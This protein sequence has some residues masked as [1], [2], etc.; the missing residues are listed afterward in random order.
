MWARFP[1]PSRPVLGLTQSPIQ[2]V[3]GFFA[4]VKGARRGVNHPPPSVV[5]VKER[6]ELYLYSAVGIHDLLHLPRIRFI[7]VLKLD[8]AQN[9]NIQ[10]WADPTFF[11]SLPSLEDQGGTRL[12]NVVMC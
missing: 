12:R 8:V 11:T 2:W 6:E 1:H 3:P 7:S 4:G 9:L 10:G 5:E